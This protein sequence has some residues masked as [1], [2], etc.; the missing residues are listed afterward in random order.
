MSKISSIEVIYLAQA[1]MTVCYA[2][3]KVAR[4]SDDY[5]KSL[6]D[7]LPDGN[8]E[9]IDNLTPTYQISESKLNK[10]EQSISE[11]INVKGRE[12]IF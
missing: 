8:F 7:I 5:K 1:M 6:K 11:K 4:I 2:K 3:T 12:A 9:G 10:L